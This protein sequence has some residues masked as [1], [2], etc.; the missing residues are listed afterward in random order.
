MNCALGSIAS[1][2][3]VIALAGCASTGSTSPQTE[4]G[5]PSAFGVDTSGIGPTASVATAS[6]VP[7]P[8]PT[9]E[10][11]SGP[12]TTR[13]CIVADARGMVGTVAKDESVLTKMSCFKSTVKHA[14]QGVWTVHC[15]AT[16][17]DDTLWAGI[18]SVLVNQGKVTWEATGEISGG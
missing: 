5:S 3:A 14:A 9:A 1:A 4:A 15:D 11:S 12:C 17:S 10:P 16:Y 2:I 7:P 8:V 13:A 18:A 6:S